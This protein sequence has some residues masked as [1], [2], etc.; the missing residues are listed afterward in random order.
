MGVAGKNRDQ[1][2]TSERQRSPLR[3]SFLLCRRLR[4]P[5]AF[6]LLVYKA[7]LTAF[8]E[9]PLY[10]RCPT[11]TQGLG[12]PLPSCPGSH[13]PGDS[14]DGGL[15]RRAGHSSGAPRAPCGFIGTQ[16]TAACLPPTPWGPVYPGAK[17]Q[18]EPQGLH[19]LLQLSG[20]EAAAAAWGHPW[21]TMA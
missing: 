6:L 2:G 1:K 21:I 19:H 14:W 5:P 17:T 10:A 11:H 20:L 15:G 9:H 12:F 4:S 3:L 16:P 18:G 8:S 13:T 7:Q